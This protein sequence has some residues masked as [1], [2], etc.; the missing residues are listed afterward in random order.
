MLNIKRLHQTIYSEKFS[1]DGTLTKISCYKFH[2]GPPIWL[3][4]NRGEMPLFWYNYLMSEVYIAGKI[5]SDEL[6]IASFSDELEQ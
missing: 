5:S 3:C 2:D 1:L 4:L 6:T